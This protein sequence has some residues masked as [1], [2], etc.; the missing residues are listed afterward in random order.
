MCYTETIDQSTVTVNVGRYQS[1]LH[2]QAETHSPVDRRQPSAIHRI[3]LLRPPAHRP[4]AV[5]A[6]AH[7]CR[8]YRRHQYLRK[9]LTTTCLKPSL[10]ANDS[11]ALVWCG[12]LCTG[13]SAH[14]KLVIQRMPVSSSLRHLMYCLCWSRPVWTRNVQLEADI[15]PHDSFQGDRAAGAGQT[16]APP[17]C[18]CE[19]CSSTVGVPARTF[20]RNSCT[21]WTVCMRLPTRR[22][23]LCWLALTFRQPLIPPTM[24]SSSAVSKVSLA[25]TAV[26]PTGCARTSQ[27]GSSSWNSAIIH[28]PRRSAPLQLLKGQW[29]DHCSSQHTCRRSESSSSF[30]W[31]LISSVWW[32]HAAARRHKRHWRWTGSRKTRQLLNRCST[33][34]LAQR[35]TAQ[36]RQVPGRHS[37]HCTS[38]PV[39]C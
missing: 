8:H 9:V 32:R 34:V 3:W 35:P 39:G 10:T 13:H 7:H 20:N 4:D 25:L 38:A 33:V 12:R 30:I 24:T 5:P 29:S 28:R 27:T 2:R 16:E 23:L 21:S 22:R 37:W 26:L 19:L 14:G 36:L 15:E 17:A 18:V 11:A 6:A 31:R 1:V